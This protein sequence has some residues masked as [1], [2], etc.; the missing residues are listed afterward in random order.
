MQRKNATSTETKTYLAM[1]TNAGVRQ[2][3]HYLGP[4]VSQANM[5]EWVDP[6]TPLLGGND[7]THAVWCARGPTQCANFWDPKVRPGD[8]V[9]IQLRWHVA[10]G[11]KSYEGHFV[12]EPVVR[13][14]AV[15]FPPDDKL[16]YTGIGGAPERAKNFRVGRIAMNGI[17]TVHDEL[18]YATASGMD[19]SKGVAHY[20]DQEAA[21][22]AAGLLE[23]VQINVSPT[24]QMRYVS[25]V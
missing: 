11:Q 1:L 8:V 10:A 12:L 19:P 17:Q 23:R 2:M 22:K 18:F 6:A 24:F 7:T 25:W 4:C 21:C 20:G 14:G 15:D 3:L 9:W 16:V 13:L 5:M